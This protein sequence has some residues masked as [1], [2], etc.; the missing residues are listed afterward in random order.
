[1]L[2]TILRDIAICIAFFLWIWILFTVL[3]DLFRRHDTPKFIKILWIIFIILLP[4]LGVFVYLIVQRKGMTER[5]LE[6]H[7]AASASSGEHA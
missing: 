3:A 4:Y 7:A 6:Q 1:M 5:A 2:L